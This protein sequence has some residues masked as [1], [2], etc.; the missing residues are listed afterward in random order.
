MEGRSQKLVWE[1]PLSSSPSESDPLSSRLGPLNWI[2]S[3]SHPPSPTHPHS[4]P[5]P[6]YLSMENILNNAYWSSADT[7]SFPSISQ[8][9]FL[10]CVCVYL[11][12]TFLVLLQTGKTGVDPVC[13]PCLARIIAQTIAT[14]PHTSGM[15]WHQSWH[16]GQLCV[17]SSCVWVSVFSFLWIGE[18][19]EDGCT[20]QIQYYIC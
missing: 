12:L 11:S 4:P 1:G 10:L 8:P 6:H 18:R 13:H 2:C 3:Y 17:C 15:A 7:G 20:C 14:P 16:H 9:L 19:G 5:P